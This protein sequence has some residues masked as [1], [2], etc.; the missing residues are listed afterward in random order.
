MDGEECLTNSPQPKSTSM[1]KRTIET[2][3]S[4]Y[5]LN[6]KTLKN[7]LNCKHKEKKKNPSFTFR[8]AKETKAHDFSRDDFFR[9]SL[10]Y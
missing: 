5:L 4:P 9:R 6:N 10:F 2:N 3:K 1:G 7:I 8:S